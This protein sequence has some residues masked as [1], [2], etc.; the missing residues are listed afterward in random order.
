MNYYQETL[1]RLRQADNLRH[2]PADSTASDLVDLSGNDYLGIAADEHLK[3]EFIESLANG[4]TLPALSASASRLLASNQKEFS[5][6]ESLLRDLY[7]APVLLFNSGYHANAGAISALARERTLIVADKLVHASII[8]G[9]I[10]SKAPFERFRHNDVAHLRRILDKRAKDFDRVLIVCE[11]I[12]SMDGDV[13]P[14]GEIADAKT[15]NSLL[16]VDEAHAFGVMGREGLGLT[17][18]MPEVDFTVGTLGK[19]AGSVGAF[20]VC[21]NDGAREYL[22]NTARS[23]IFSTAIPPIN[24]AW[25]RFVIERIPSMT[26]RREH[27]QTLSRRL[28]DILGIENATHIQPFITGS[29]AMAIELSR[30]LL[31]AGYKV[32]PIRTPTVPPG[33]ERLR[34]SLSADLDIEQLDNL[35]AAL[36]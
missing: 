18:D 29:S 22:V 6:L 25:S 26:D 31:D 16:Y 15:S 20:I 23:F 8:D 5:A 32:L 12:Y 14:L 2:I 30:K 27:L 34:F 4:G 19:A 21:R 10:L 9:M 1:N 11:S 33:T 13:A 7:G 17:A 3:A 28:G 35:S 36:K 24:C